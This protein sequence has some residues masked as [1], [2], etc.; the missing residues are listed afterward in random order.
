MRREIQEA[1]DLGKANRWDEAIA[2]MKAVVD[3]EPTADHWA[4]LGTTYRSCSRWDE[5]DGAYGKA[6]ALERR[7]VGALWGLGLS[8]GMQGDTEGA[9]EMLGEA[10]DAAPRFAPPRFQLALTLLAQ[11]DDAGA[12]AHAE[13]LRELDGRYA[14]KLDACLRERGLLSG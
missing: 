12:L 6:L 3:E 1:L 11:G 8:R 13:V 7:H 14:A 5:A 4:Y 2:K 9:A 10:V